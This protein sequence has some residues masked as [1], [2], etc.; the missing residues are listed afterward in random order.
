MFDDLLQVSIRRYDPD[1]LGL[2]G[3]VY[4]DGS[5]EFYGDDPKVRLRMPKGSYSLIEDIR[6]RD[7]VRLP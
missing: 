2:R 5:V 4:E 3:W 6:A 1:L 7:A